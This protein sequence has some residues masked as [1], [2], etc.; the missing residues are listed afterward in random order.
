V[1]QISLLRPGFGF[2]RFADFLAVQFSIPAAESPNVPARAGGSQIPVLDKTGLQGTYEFSVDL[3]PEL[4]TDMF[5]AWKRALGVQ[6]GLKI[7]SQKGDVA[8]VVVD[9][10]AKIPAEN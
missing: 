6:L 5:T 9:D 7:E 10:V 8:G 3:E 4:G 1:A 2:K